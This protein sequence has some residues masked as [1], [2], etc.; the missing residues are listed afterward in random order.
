M[1]LGVGEGRVATEREDVENADSDRAK[2]GR[3]VGEAGTTFLCAGRFESSRL[4][5][6][7]RVVSKNK[8]ACLVRRTTAARLRV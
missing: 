7:F 2:L 1:A 8:S 3:Q 5:R 6:D 4:Q